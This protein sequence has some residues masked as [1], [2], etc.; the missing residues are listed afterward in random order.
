M[1]SAFRR[2]SESALIHPATVTAI[3]VLL[4]NDMVLPSWRVDLRFAS[5]GV[6]LVNNIE[7]NSVRRLDGLGLVAGGLELC[8]YFEVRHWVGVAAR[9]HQRRLT[10]VP[11]NAAVGD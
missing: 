5:V 2:R 7:G 8:G 10:P 11:T 4:L 6:A 9:L 1:S 3:V